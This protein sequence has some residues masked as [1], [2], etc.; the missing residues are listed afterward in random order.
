MTACGRA[1]LVASD[2]AAVFAPPDYILFAR[3]EI[4]FAQ[5]LDLQPLELLGDPFVMADRVA[6]NPNT[7]T[8]SAVSASVPGATCPERSSC[9]KSS[10]TIW[11]G[12]SRCP[13]RA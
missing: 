8:D 2:S 1:C 13:T 9:R 5:R 11:G 10:S 6:L 3:Q 4:L 12:I 7:F